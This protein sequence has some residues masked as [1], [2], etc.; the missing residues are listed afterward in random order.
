MSEVG[1]IKAASEIDMLLLGVAF[2]PAVEREALRGYTRLSLVPNRGVDDTCRLWFVGR[3]VDRV[4]GII[5]I[6]YILPYTP[7]MKYQV[8]GLR[9]SNI[10][11]YIWLPLMM[12]TLVC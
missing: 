11:H 1:G 4:N 9:F 6:T 8:C 5:N 10:T 12:Y 7:G 2:C 3:L